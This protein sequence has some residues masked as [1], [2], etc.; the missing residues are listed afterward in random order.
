MHFFTISVHQ[1]Y[2][3][4]NQTQNAF[5]EACSDRNLSI[6]TLVGK[7]HPVILNKRMFGVREISM[8]FEFFYNFSQGFR[9]EEFNTILSYLLHVRNFQLKWCSMK[10][11]QHFAEKF[12][13]KYQSIVHVSVIFFNQ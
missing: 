11:S 5:G 9:Y 7:L 8:P 4:S 2:N 13:S 10:I 12:F 6:N 1:L 3:G